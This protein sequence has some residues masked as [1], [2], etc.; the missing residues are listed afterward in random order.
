MLGGSHFAI[1]M[2]QVPTM[3]DYNI[4]REPKPFERPL[5]YAPDTEKRVAY[6][7]PST[8]G[9]DL[10]TGK[11]LVPWE[12][13]MVAIGLVKKPNLYARIQAIVAR[14]GGWKSDKV[15]LQRIM[16]D[17]K[18]AAD[19][20]GQADRG[21]A[22]HD[23][24][25]AA[26]QGTLDH[27]LV[28]EHLRGP[29]F[30]YEENVVPKLTYLATECFVAVDRLVELPGREPI[31]LRAAGS[32]DRVCEYKGK[33]YIVDIKS[34]RDDEFRTGVC[35]QLWLYSVGKLYADDVVT[36]MEQH[37][38]GAGLVDNWIS[39]D[40]VPDD[41]EYGAHPINPSWRADLGVNQ[42]WAIMLQAPKFAT[43]GE[44]KWRFH[45]I[46][47]DTGRQIV[48]CGQWARKCRSVKPFEEFEL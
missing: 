20:K 34:G 18:E 30:W 3:T 42:E 38:P 16:S 5:L 39:A 13:S 12:Q 10:D 43:R 28:P 33:R 47:L 35:G 29:V 41:S 32:I 26:E 1:R 22:I 31:K 2:H 9:K 24:C 27:D 15:Q 36:Q 17:A 46:P 25:D 19:W 44:W 11:S 6:S 21:S 4:P 14:G 8:L 23:F 40:D 48:E 45:W 37:P 7:R